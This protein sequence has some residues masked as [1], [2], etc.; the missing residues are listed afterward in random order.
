MAYDDL[1]MN[2]RRRRIIANALDVALDHVGV[3]GGSSFDKTHRLLIDCVKDAGYRRSSR[4]QQ[5]NL[6]EIALHASG[7]SVPSLFFRMAKMI[8][9]AI[10]RD[11][12]EMGGSAARLKPKPT[13]PTDTSRPYKDSYERSE[14]SFLGRL[15]GR[16]KEDSYLDR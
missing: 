16:K 3:S 8:A 9:E 1:E 2:E 14:E 7:L 10:D 4:N 5:I 6:L 15:F 13:P 11:D 12:P